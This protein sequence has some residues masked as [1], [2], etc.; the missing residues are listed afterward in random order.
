MTTPEMLQ[1]RRDDPWPNNDLP[2]LIWRGVA[3]D[4]EIDEVFVR[5]GWAGIWH[6]G[7]FDFH[8]FH[9][10]AH[11]AL[12]CQRGWVEVMLGGPN[13]EQV[14]LNAGDIVALPAGTSHQNIRHSSDYHI[15]G[16][17]PPGQSPDMEYGDERHVHACVA[18]IQRVPER[19]NDPVSGEPWARWGETTKG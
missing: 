17:Y 5:N 2:V 1:L 3:R 11:E 16:A 10:T 4:E 9:A 6:N 7:I 19:V 8:H 18:A 12:G 13:G 14:R 15:V